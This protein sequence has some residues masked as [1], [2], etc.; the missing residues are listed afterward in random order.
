MLRSDYLSYMG[1]NFETVNE[2]NIHTVLKISPEPANEPF[3]IYWLQIICT[4]KKVSL[5]LENHSYVVGSIGDFLFFAISI[6]VTVNI[7][8]YKM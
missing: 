3:Y 8:N 1:Y 6:E 2:P 5:T 4:F 7:C